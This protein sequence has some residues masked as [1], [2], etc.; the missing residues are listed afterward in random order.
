MY[1]PSRQVRDAQ[2]CSYTVI[3]YQ[4]QMCSCAMPLLVMAQWYC[5]MQANN[6]IINDRVQRN[7]ECPD[8]HSGIMPPSRGSFILS[9]AERV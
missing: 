1:K 3:D 8:S 5:V 9:K 6:H 7:K 4:R 2:S